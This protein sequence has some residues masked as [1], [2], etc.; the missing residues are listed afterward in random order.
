MRLL[1]QHTEFLPCSD[2]G[3]ITPTGTFTF[4]VEGTNKS[5]QFTQKTVRELTQASFSNATIVVYNAEL[6]RR[7]T[8]ISYQLLLGRGEDLNADLIRYR[9]KTLF[10]EI[11]RLV[12]GKQVIT[13]DN[14]E[15]SVH[16]VLV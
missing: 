16:S 3:V 14:R 11:A 5:V 9:R 6:P 15:D 8:T 1:I 4:L 7:E 13:S 10:S 2:M 12:D